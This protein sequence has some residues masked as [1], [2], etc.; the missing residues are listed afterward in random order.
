MDLGAVMSRQQAARRE[1]DNE[2]GR[3]RP[4]GHLSAGILVHP[5]GQGALAAVA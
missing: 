2:P 4:A 5:V 3:K 1:L